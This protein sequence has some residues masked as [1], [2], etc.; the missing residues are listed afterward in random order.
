MSLSEDPGI[1]VP[2]VFKDENILIYARHLLKRPGWEKELMDHTVD[3]EFVHKNQKELILQLDFHYFTEFVDIDPSPGG[4][5]IHSMSEPFEEDDVEDEVK[6]NWLDRFKFNFHQ[7]H[8][9]GHCSKEEIF[10]ILKTID[11]K[12]VF[13]VHT[14]HPEMFKKAAKGVVPLELCKTYEL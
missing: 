2:D 7:Y 6:H 1:E 5:F 13:P 12:K 11:A 3:A 8:A 14:E 10:D 4:H 9:S